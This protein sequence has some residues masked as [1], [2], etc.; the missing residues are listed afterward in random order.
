M[1]ENKRRV[2]QYLRENSFE[3]PPTVRELCDKL[4]IKSTSSVHRILHQ[5]EEEGLITLAKGK[6]RN[7]QLAGRGSAVQ[8]PLVGTVAAGLP[9]LAQENIED[10]VVFDGALRDK[11]GLFALRVKGDSMINAGILDG[12]IIVAKQQVTA[13]DGEIIVA[14]LGDEATVKRL[15]RHADHIELRAE[16]PD[17]A[18]IEATDVS[19]LGRVVACLRYYEAEGEYR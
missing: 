11:T 12:D 1:S 7:I 2:L 16:N 3:V 8:V 19:V 6:R 15:Y 13:R 5:L 10:Y 17:Y 4:G 14:L 9:I 18:P